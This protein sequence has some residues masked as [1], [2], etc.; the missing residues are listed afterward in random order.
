MDEISKALE[1]LEGAGLIEDERFARELVRD[2]ARRRLVGDRVIRNAL[3]QKGVAADI[4]ESALDEAGGE[5][6]RAIELASRSAGRLRGL[7]RDAAHR[8]LYRL[9]LRR[10]FGHAIAAEG[11]RRALDGYLPAGFE[12]PSD[13]P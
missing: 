4:V 12:E 5:D 3:R 1:E 6:E 10:G 7:D 8:R 13:S 9:L 2:H 11:A